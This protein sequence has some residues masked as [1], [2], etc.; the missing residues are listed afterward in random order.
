MKDNN[1]ETVVKLLNGALKMLQHAQDEVVEFG[2]GLLEQGLATDIREQILLVNRLNN[3]VI[4]RQRVLK[5]S[6]GSSA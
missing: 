6:G 2:A 1:Y 3:K 4:N 5:F